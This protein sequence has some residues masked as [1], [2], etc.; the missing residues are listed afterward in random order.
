V[1]V[2]PN[3]NS[4]EGQL[5]NKSDDSGPV[6]R[7]L[8]ISECTLSRDRRLSLSVQGVSNF[9]FRLG[10]HVRMQ[11]CLFATRHSSTLFRECLLPIG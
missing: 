8:L 7:V 4:V 3:A 1:I 5:P 9:S 10:G 2:V 6:N 11:V